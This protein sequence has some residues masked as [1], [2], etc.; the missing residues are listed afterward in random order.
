M[1]LIKGRVLELVF[2]QGAKHGSFLHIVAVDH[3]MRRWDAQV[4]ALVQKQRARG[5]LL[6]GSVVGQIKGIVP[7]QHRL[8]QHLRDGKPAHH[9]PVLL[10]QLLEAFGNAQL[11]VVRIAGCPLGSKVGGGLGGLPGL[12]GKCFRRRDRFRNRCFHGGFCWCRDGSLLR[13]RLTG[14]IGAAQFVAGASGPAD[15]DKITDQ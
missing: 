6:S 12:R 1:F 7:L 2:F 15:I 4:A 11:G 9:V 13:E 3:Q 14:G 10:A 8:V 5:V